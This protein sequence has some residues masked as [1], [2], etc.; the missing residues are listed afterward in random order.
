MRRAEARILSQFYSDPPSWRYRL[1]VRK[2]REEARYA[3][4]YWRLKRTTVPAARA[5]FVAWKLWAASAA[6]YA[7][8]SYLEAM[9]TS[10]HSTAGSWWEAVDESPKEAPS[11][12]RTS[13]AR[14]TTTCGRMWRARCATAR[15]SSIRV[16]YPAKKA[17]SSTQPP[18]LRRTQ[19]PHSAATATD[20]PSASVATGCASPGVSTSHGR[21]A[22]QSVFGGRSVMWFASSA[23]R[24]ICGRP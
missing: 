12:P 8:A 2:R 13:R 16:N 6:L 9:R 22:C 23:P 7:E 21:V 14:R 11:P 18:V 20:A 3:T 10:L 24:P 19:S 5:I 4:G 17:S 1:R 15:Q